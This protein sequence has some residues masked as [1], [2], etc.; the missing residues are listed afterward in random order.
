MGRITNNNRCLIK[1]LQTEKNG[2]KRLIKEFLKKKLTLQSIK[3]LLKKENNGLTELH[4][5]RQRQW[6]L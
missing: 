1:G 4:E 3:R 2:A 6:P 5:V